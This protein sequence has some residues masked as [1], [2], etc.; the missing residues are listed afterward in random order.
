MATGGES[1]GGARASGSAGMGGSAGASSGSAGTAGGGSAGIGSGSGGSSAGGA[2]GAGANGAAGRGSGG[3]AGDGAS[4]GCSQGFVPVEAGTPNVL[5]ACQVIDAP[6]TYTLANDLSADADTCL[7]IRDTSSVLLDC[8]SHRITGSVALDIENVHGFEIKNC[9]LNVVSGGTLSAAIRNSQNGGLHANTSSGGEL[10]VSS[11]QAIQVFENDLHSPFAQYG[12]TDSLL[13]CNTIT[14]PYV[15][16]DVAAAVVI[17]ENGASNVVTN[18][19]LDGSWQPLEGNYGADDGIEVSDE[20]DDTISDNMIA[21]NWDC[22][23]ESSGTIAN[24]VFS[25]NSISSSGVAGIGGWYYLNHSNVTYS[26]NVIDGA[27]QAFLFT[28]IYGLRANETAVLFENNQFIANQFK[29][30]YTPGNPAARIPLYDALGFNGIPGPGQ[31][32]PTIDQFLLT[33]N[34]FADN[35]FGGSQGPIFGALLV[36]GYVIDGGGNICTTP[37]DPGYPLVCVY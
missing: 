3:S 4:S 6:G 35:D 14:N 9:V 2:G 12:T 33:N 36:P 34:L 28:R 24:T 18:N 22:G 1:N 29:N 32:V 15:Y 23:I 17:L 16:P 7:T 27:P 31:T 21:N 5:T 13:A 10:G 19:T 25:G 37:A 20:H 30:P 26:H 11:C 8:A